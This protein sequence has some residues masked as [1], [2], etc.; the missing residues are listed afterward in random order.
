MSVAR[1]HRDYFA[2]ITPLAEERCLEFEK[3]AVRSLERQRQIEEN[4]EISFDEYL[5]NYFS[6]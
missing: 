4:D 6:S 5:D 1:S 2:A 3:E